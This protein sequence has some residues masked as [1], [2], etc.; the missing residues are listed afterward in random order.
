MINKNEE[1]KNPHETSA[2]AETNPKI[3]TN[4]E[5]RQ[6]KQFSLDGDKFYEMQKF[7]EAITAY[8]KAIEKNP[9][10]FAF[11]NNRGVAFHAKGDYEQAIADYTKAVEL[12]PY[13][14]SSYNNRGA[15]YEDIGVIERAIADYQKALELEPDNK[16]AQMNLNK[17]L[18]KKK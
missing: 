12:N 8:T 5:V 3:P 4:D 17:I 1:I 7:D 9:N 18:G 11:Y 6:S 14:F 13:H 2:T 16:T 15:A 10:D